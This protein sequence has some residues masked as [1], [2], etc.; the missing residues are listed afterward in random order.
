MINFF[1]ES[2]VVLC[3][4]IF[5]FFLLL[6]RIFSEAILILK[7]CQI[8]SL[9]VLKQRYTIWKWSKIIFWFNK[10]KWNYEIKSFLFLH[11]PLWQEIYDWIGPATSSMKFLFSKITKNNQKITNKIEELREEQH[12][13]MPRILR[14]LLTDSSTSKPRNFT[15]CDNKKLTI[16]DKSISDFTWLSKGSFLPK[17]IVKVITCQYQLYLIKN[18]KLK[19]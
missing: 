3:S 12:Q 10:F 17:G 8:T 4:I 6:N 18:S 19:L 1:I 5:S 16:L 2:L 14:K 9:Y 7:L 15:F 11:F 13:K